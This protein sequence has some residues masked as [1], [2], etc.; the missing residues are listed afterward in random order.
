[1]AQTTRIKHAKA[2]S[3]APNLIAQTLHPH[4]YPFNIE[5]FLH[6]L[7]PRF[8]HTQLFSP[9]HASIEYI[10]PNLQPRPSSQTFPSA[11]K[12]YLH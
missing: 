11:L 12:T 2:W 1:M 3:L 5:G 4:N 7:T 9:H 10:P 6:Q 8:S